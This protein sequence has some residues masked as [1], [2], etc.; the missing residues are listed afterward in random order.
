MVSDLHSTT[1]NFSKISDSI[2][3]AELSYEQAIQYLKKEDIKD[4]IF[5]KTGWT[6]MQYQN[7]NLGWAKVLPNRINNYY[8]MNGRI[9][10]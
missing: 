8:P 7:Q 2:Q 1:L 4:L 6:L 9:L 5:D 10:K 3:K